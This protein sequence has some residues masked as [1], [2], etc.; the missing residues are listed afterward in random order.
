MGRDQ[1][2][3]A[4]GRHVKRREIVVLGFRGVGK[5]SITVQFCEGTWVEEYHPTIENTFQ[6]F[7][8]FRGEDISL[9]ILDT[10]GQDELTIFSARHMVGIHGYLLVYDVTSRHSFRVIKHIHDRILN[11]YLG[12][13]SRYL[14]IVLVANK[15]DLENCRVVSVSEGQALANDWGCAFVECSAKHGENI[16]K[17]FLR[18]LHHVQ[19][20]EEVPVDEDTSGPCK[21]YPLCAFCCCFPRCFDQ[22]RSGNS[23]LGRSSQHYRALRSAG[24]YGEMSSTAGGRRSRNTSS[25]EDDVYGYGKE[26]R[27][28]TQNCLGN[29]FPKPNVSDDCI[30]KLR[31]LLCMLSIV[32]LLIGGEGIATGVQVVTSPGHKLKGPSPSSEIRPSSSPSSI[33]QSPSSL[34]LAEHVATRTI[35]RHSIPYRPTNRANLQGAFFA[36]GMIGLGLYSVAVG[37]TGILGAMRGS[38]NL[39]QLFAF[40]S[41]VLLFAHIV[42]TI[43]VHVDTSLL[44]SISWASDGINLLAAM[45]VVCFMDSLSTAVAFFLQRNIAPEEELDADHPYL[46]SNFGDEDEASRLNYGTGSSWVGGNAQLGASAYRARG[47]QWKEW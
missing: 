3:H 13:T 42:A 8:N 19:Q 25:W 41:A 43:A 32:L 40:S 23:D 17:A 30:K 29:S 15:S 14:P 31:I 37:V 2:P 20:N 34:G 10:T 21:E 7:L 46:A 47:S 44:P 45:I 1:N 6:K 39:I 24:S 33:P 28:C 4:L 26:S 35:L 11:A 18:L 27:C 36:Y 9:Q 5:S 12:D 16:K 22:R 38:R